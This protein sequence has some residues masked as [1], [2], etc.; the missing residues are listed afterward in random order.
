L[1]GLTYRASTELARPHFGATLLEV[2]PESNLQKLAVTFADQAFHFGWAQL[3]LGWLL[4]LCAVMLQYV[5]DAAGLFGAS[6]QTKWAIEPW[7]VRTGATLAAAD[8]CRIEEVEEDL[9]RRFLVVNFR[10]QSGGA[11]RKLLL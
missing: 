9:E 11:P 1:L 5:L 8:R 3:E 6:E 4:A 2:A 10:R 7:L